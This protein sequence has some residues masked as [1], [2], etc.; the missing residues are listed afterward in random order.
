MRMR[1]R[2]LRI[3]TAVTLAAGLG[4]GTPVWAQADTQARMK[5]ATTARA[6]E[7]ASAQG[8]APSA[9]TASDTQTM[10]AAARDAWLAGK[11][12]TALLFT[13]ELNSFA[14]DTKVSS[15]VARLSGSVES[16]VERDLAGEIARSVDGIEKV[17]NALEINAK[18]ARSKRASAAQARAEGFRAAVDNA[19]VTARI[20]TEL[21]ANTNVSGTAIDVDSM[22]H[23]VTLSGTVDS[24]ASREL[25]EQIAQGAADGREVE[26]NLNVAS[27]N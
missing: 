8:K 22:V 21:L 23:T 1:Q 14:I 25:A 9:R 16:Q 26:N 17:E 3:A 12:E 15:G 4:A 2:A 24:D 20:K 5:P 27:G 6:S 7:Q 10:Q 11:L 19:A 18:N 13:D